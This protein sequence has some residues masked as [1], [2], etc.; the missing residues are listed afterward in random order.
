MEHLKYKSNI[1]YFYENQSITFIAANQKFSMKAPEEIYLQIH[2]MLGNLAEGMPSDKV[3]SQY[4]HFNQIIRFFKSVGILYQID[5]HLLEKHASKDYFSKVETLASDVVKSLELIEGSEFKICSQFA[6]SKEVTRLLSNN[7]LKHLETNGEEDFI[8]SNEWEYHYVNVAVTG[9]KEIMVA[10][11][12]RKSFEF[13]DRYPLSSEYISLP[14]LAQFVF[15]TLIESIISDEPQLFLI[16]ENLEVKK[17]KVFSLEAS[18]IGSYDTNEILEQVDLDNEDPFQ[19]L[20]ALERFI[21]QYS[22]K[23]ISF[24]KNSGYGQYVQLPLQVFTAQYY[25]IDNQYRNLYLA[26]INYE[27]LSRFFV[28]AGFSELLKQSY[29]NEYRVSRKGEMIHNTKSLSDS[30]WVKEIDLHELD[31]DDTIQ[32]LLIETRLEIDIQIQ[33]YSD[34]RYVVYIY[35]NAV[36]KTF[37]FTVPI[38]NEAY[39]NIAI[40]TYI[41]AVTNMIDLSDAAFAEATDMSVPVHLRNNH[42][43]E[44]WKQTNLKHIL[45][46]D[47]F[48]YEFWEMKI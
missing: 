46:G 32:E 12:R 22:S 25:D 43:S 23:I 18:E 1:R 27:R 47:R 14:L 45:G 17:K 20:N 37:T 8:V 26:D 35:D 30:T 28:E 40:Y 39:I 48:N 16:N 5:S 36:Q 38:Y 15:H 29:G 19:S 34:N 42:A 4:G 11:I 33:L 2:Q 24:N 41:S 44:G 13:M 31:D 6:A 9:A 7:G 10:P 3:E 21:D